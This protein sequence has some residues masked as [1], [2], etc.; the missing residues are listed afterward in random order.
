MFG[1]GLMQMKWFQ[2]LR[3]NPYRGKFDLVKGN[4]KIEYCPGSVGESSS[5]RD[6]F[7]SKVLFT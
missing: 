5:I 6:F 4:S 3:L 7:R 1:D 2:D